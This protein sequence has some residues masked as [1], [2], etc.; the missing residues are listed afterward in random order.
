[1]NQEQLAVH[2]A[3]ARAGSL[4]YLL[5]LAQLT[6][7]VVAM[8]QERNSVPIAAAP[9]ACNISLSSRLESQWITLRGRVFSMARP[10]PYIPSN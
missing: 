3:M 9:E 6:N 2:S 4:A 10:S 7:A 8:G 1:M 5:A